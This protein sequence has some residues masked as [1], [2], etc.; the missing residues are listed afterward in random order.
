MA[1]KKNTAAAADNTKR[2]YRLKTLYTETVVPAL[3][4][5]F[6]YSNINEVPKLEKIVLNMGFP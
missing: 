4:S 3:M 2:V 1:G 5:K 6:N